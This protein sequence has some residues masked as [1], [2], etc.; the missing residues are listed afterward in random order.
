MFTFFPT[1]FSLYLAFVSFPKLSPAQNLISLATSPNHRQVFAVLGDVEPGT[2]L[3]DF[4]PTGSGLYFGDMSLG[5]L[6]SIDLHLKLAH[7][8]REDLVLTYE[9]PFGND[10]EFDLSFKVNRVD[11]SVSHPMGSKIFFQHNP[12]DTAIAKFL[13]KEG[14]LIFD[15]N[16][17]TTAFGVYAEVEARDRY[18][19]VL[20][21]PERA[22]LFGFQVFSGTADTMKEIP[23]NKS[24]YEYAHNDDPFAPSI[25]RLDA[26]NG[27]TIKLPKPGRNVPFAPHYLLRDGQKRHLKPLK[28][29]REMLE[30]LGM[31]ADHLNMNDVG[32]CAN[33]FSR[34]SADNSM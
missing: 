23:L 4:R 33:L 13:R 22:P 10:L 19:F 34:E 27:A 5:V 18:L 12:T 28:Q 26:Q 2:S 3:I 29:S 14:R 9:L 8:D 1:L 30:A 7:E 17:H 20:K 16:F 24:G 6:H 25:L 32:I 21:K 31:E 11:I 15:P